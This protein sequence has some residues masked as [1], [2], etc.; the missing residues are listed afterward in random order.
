MALAIIL[1]LVCVITP[2]ILQQYRPCPNG[3]VLKRLEE[4]HAEDLAQTW[5]YFDNVQAKIVYFKNLIKHLNSVGIFSQKDPN[6]PIAW[7][8]EYVY[9]QPAHLYVKEQ[10]RRRGFASLMMKYICECIEAK[11]LMPVVS[12]DPDNSGSLELMRKL[13]F[14]QY[15]RDEYIPIG[16]GW[17][18]HIWT[19]QLSNTV[20]SPDDVASTGIIIIYHNNYG[21]F[22]TESFIK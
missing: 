5:S 9:G 21:V 10:F 1:L 6:T 16:D 12:V 2:W 13:G 14:V 8:V 18:W 19:I 22:D 3:F 7:C 11:G 20:T 17:C 15:G 4:H